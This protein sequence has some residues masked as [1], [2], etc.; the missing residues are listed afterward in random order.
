MTPTTPE[1]PL[2][3]TTAQ[4]LVATLVRHLGKD[5]ALAVILDCLCEGSTDPEVEPRPW[6][7][8]ATLLT[9]EQ[10]VRLATLADRVTI[11]AAIPGLTPA[12][13]ASLTLGADTIA[14]S[15]DQDDVIAAW[16]SRG[17]VMVDPR[18]PAPGGWEIPDPAYPLDLGLI[19]DLQRPSGEVV[20]AAIVATIHG[21]GAEEIAW[22]L[23]VP[24]R[25]E[26]L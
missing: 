20:H 15:D 21:H 24:K 11:M 7:A 8:D 12:E 13:C 16:I 4:A 6:L 26:D 3:V 18:S 10:R 25:G 14:L 1:A 5:W 9:R 23:Y 19:V 17:A 2:A 22:M